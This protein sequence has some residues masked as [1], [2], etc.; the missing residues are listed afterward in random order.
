[1][2]ASVYSVGSKPEEADQENDNVALLIGFLAI[3]FR[4]LHKVPVGCVYSLICNQLYPVQWHFYV[5]VQ[6]TY[7]C[8]FAIAI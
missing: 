3:L 7:N 4:I 5:H 8:E 6:C 1:M 2:L